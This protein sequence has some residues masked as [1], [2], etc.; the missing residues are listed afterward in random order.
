MIRQATNND[1]NGVE[2]ITQAVWNQKIDHEVFQNQIEN[3][4]C[5]IHVAIEHNQVAGFLSSFLTIDVHHNRRWEV[6]LLVVRPENQGYGLG[7][8]LI[9]SVWDDAQKH[10]AGFARAMVRTD[11]I[12]SQKAFSRA[13]YSTNGKRHHL[14]LWPP[15]IQPEQTMLPNN[16][17]LLPMDTLTYRGLWIEG[18]ITPTRTDKEQSD[19]LSKAQNIVVTQKRLNTGAVIPMD[20]E[21]VLSKDLLASGTIHGEY[22]WW[23]K[24]LKDIH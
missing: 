7:T 14:Y 11:N 20:E 13:G 16:V 15:Q 12:A 17:T 4:T 23:V 6:D 5:V 10:R 8:A 21:T 3:D 22:G 19:I 24:S 9:Q 1:A 18:L 2:A